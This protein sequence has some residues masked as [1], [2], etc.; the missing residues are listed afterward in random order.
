M[1]VVSGVCESAWMCAGVCAGVLMVCVRCVFV[2]V[3]F[4]VLLSR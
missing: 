3:E 1:Y 4:W 2:K